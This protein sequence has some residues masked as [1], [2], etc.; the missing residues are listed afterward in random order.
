MCLEAR[1]VY[2]ECA[3]GLR[4]AG[5]N[6]AVAW[7]GQG[8]CSHV[9]H[10]RPATLA[11]RSF[12]AISCAGCRVD[13]G[14]G[15]RKG[16]GPRRSHWRQQRC[17][18]VGERGTRDDVGAVFA[19][20]RMQRSGD[21]ARRYRRVSWSDHAR[22]RDVDGNAGDVADGDGD[23]RAA[24]GRLRRRTLMRVSDR[25]SAESAKPQTRAALLRQTRCVQ[26]FRRPTRKGSNTRA[27]ALIPVAGGDPEIAP[28]AERQIPAPGR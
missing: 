19:A 8:A 14:A 7:S 17:G 22:D 23:A 4:S 21:A 13:L 11:I 25:A 2:W 18:C 10:H 20:D 28:P 27:S 1:R 12:I 3:C 6:H 16:A 24:A 5:T 9:Q 26:S 15:W